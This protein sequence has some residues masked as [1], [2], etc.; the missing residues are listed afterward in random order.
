M[1]TV[2]SVCHGEEVCWAC[3]EHCEN[4]VGGMDLMC[5]L[6]QVCTKQSWQKNIYCAN[7]NPDTD[8]QCG[9]RFLKELRSWY[10]CSILEY[11]L[12]TTIATRI[13]TQPLIW[14]MGSSIFVAMSQLKVVSMTWD[15]LTI[16]LSTESASREK[17][18]RRSWQCCPCLSL[19]NFPHW[20]KSLSIPSVF[21][22]SDSA[23]L[24]LTPMIASVWLSHRTRIDTPHLVSE[25]LLPWHTSSSVHCSP[26]ELGFHHVRS[27]GRRLV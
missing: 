16:I 20:V 14:K 3:E 4:L 9:Y 8:S 27:E 23:S 7:P 13:S 10:T 2:P 19:F 15:P 6:A 22:D 11:D 24:R 25:M 17:Y 26:G 1:G 18:F 12:T 5:Q 21:N